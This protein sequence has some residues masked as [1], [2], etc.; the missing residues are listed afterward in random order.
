MRI[1]FITSNRIGDAIL[2]S[3][4]LAYL[5]ERHRGARITVACGPL[6]AS[7]FVHAPGVEKVIP[8]RKE[9]FAGHWLRLLTQTMFRRWDL[10]IDLRGSATA[11]LLF[12]GER[13]IL[14][15][16][17][18]KPRV[19]HIASVLE[20]VDPPAPRLWPGDAARAKARGLVPDGAVA[21]AIG[22]TANWPRKAWPAERFAELVERLT[23]KGGALEGAYV[24]LEAGPDEG[25]ACAP[26][27]ASIPPER[28]I[29]QIGS[30]LNTA[31][32]TFERVRLYIGN[33]SGLMHLAAAAGAPTLGLFGPTRDDLYA[34]WGQNAAFV[35][36]HRSQAE[37]VSE[38]GFDMMAKT[39]AMLDLSVDKVE[40]AA[41]ALLLRTQ[42]PGNKGRDAS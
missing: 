12:A 42:E 3:G 2:S 7:L 33:D 21:L 35:R 38:P 28:L 40:E 41:K 11:W 29:N 20:L 6:A 17:H 8:M 37:I 9:R 10:V 5:I 25:E 32:A 27:L 24:V 36:G 34:P 13:R 4:L 39:S 16:D 19:P 18:A 22:P 30:D 26:L 14:K 1:L 15:P 31:Y 23:C